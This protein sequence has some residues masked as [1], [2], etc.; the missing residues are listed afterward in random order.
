M[1]GCSIWKKPAITAFVMAAPE[2]PQ[3][4]YRK[5]LERLGRD[6]LIG[7]YRPGQK[8][9]SEAALVKRFGASRI[10]I[11]RAL[12]ELQ[13][14]G[15]IDRIAGSGTYVRNVTQ[16]PRQSLLFGLII[17]NL[18]ESEIFEPIC[19]AIAAS[20]EAAG[21]A[22]LWAHSDPRAYS[23]EDQALQLC[24]QCIA[25]SVS[26][27]FL[28]PIEMTAR[29]AEVNRQVMKSLM[30]AGIPVVLLDRRPDEAAARERVD[31][32]GIDNHRAGYLATGHLLQLGAKRVG[33]VAY[34][35]QASTVRARILGYKDALAARHPAGVPHVY[36][37]P[38]KPGWNL[39]PAALECD[40]F[41]S[42]NDRLAGELMH[43]LLA[44]GVRIPQDVRIVGIDDVNY[45]ALLPV[46]LT[47]VHQPCR[48]IGETA[49]RVMLERLDRPKMPARD[50][51]LD[52]TLVVRQ[53]CGGSKPEDS[54]NS[55]KWN[56]TPRAQ[57]VR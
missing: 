34:K 47:T 21:H 38:A 41:V 3:P 10:T 28:A 37:V 51:L 20:P 4:K 43:T 30:S 16:R 39:P 36:E 19:Q 45:A 48:D 15:L 49:L 11:G 26:G 52:C 23:K 40:G 42:A 5:I 14:Q 46:P 12:R 50:V 35:G 22:L 27:V 6:I 44:R 57:T 29:S 8:V 56:F 18:G 32:V 17:P 1:T 9:P 7:H 25:R 53:S 31:L 54:P 13:Q 24:Q 2:R 33:F 55:V